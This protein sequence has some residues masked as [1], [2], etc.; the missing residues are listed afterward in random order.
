MKYIALKE[1]TESMCEVCSTGP[2]VVVYNLNHIWAC[3][4]CI[5]GGLEF[6]A[7]EAHKKKTMPKE[8]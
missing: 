4:E 8:D 2:H 1:K 3:E 6:A 7:K 5:V